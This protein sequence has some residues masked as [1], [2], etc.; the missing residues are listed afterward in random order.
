MSRFICTAASFLLLSGGAHSLEAAPAPSAREFCEALPQSDDPLKPVQG[1]QLIRGHA[2]RKL[3]V[4]SV[5]DTP[6]GKTLWDSS[7]YFER[8]GRF[9]A[10]VHSGE[11]GGT[12]RFEGTSVRETA[13]SGGQETSFALFRR[14][15]GIIVAHFIYHYQHDDVRNFCVSFEH[16]MTQ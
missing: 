12:Y 14:R 5:M 13:D 9:S 1:L 2:L 11:V 16:P 10:S 7:T 15:D 8:N 6:Y 3:V 4:G